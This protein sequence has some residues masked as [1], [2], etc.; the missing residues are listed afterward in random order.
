MCLPRFNSSGFLY[1]YTHCLDVTSKL[2]L[3]LISPHN[4]TE[5]FQLF[6]TASSRIRDEL[7]LPIH[8]D[9]VLTI[10]SSKNGEEAPEDR[11][12]ENDIEWKR[13]GSCTME[14]EYV[15][16]P[17][18]IDSSCAL[19]KEVRQ[20]HELSSFENIAKEYF[21]G[22][23]L[24]HFLFRVDVPVKNSS[25]QSYNGKGHLTQCI[26]PPIP[27]PFLSTS[28]RRRLWSYYQKLSLR[29]RMGSATMES[30]MDAF[31]MIMQDESASSNRSFPGI[32]KHCPAMGLLESPPNT[33]GVTYI[34]EGSEIFLAMNGRDFE[35]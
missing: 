9:S 6:R 12:N 24:T 17:R 34:V 23:P 30:S 2:T 4:T 1:T 21:E 29:L 13:T 28:S 26:S 33:H 32:A 3:I 25:R 10:L 35:L 20:S 7:G 19:L 22:E 5:Q 31:D 15:N 8:S 11:K 16:V 18:D 14:E 27:F